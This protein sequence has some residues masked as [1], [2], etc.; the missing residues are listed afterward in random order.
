MGRLKLTRRV[1]PDG[2]TFA[3]FSK[4]AGSASAR[5]REMVERGCNDVVACSSPVRSKYPIAVTAESAT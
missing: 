1:N 4:G 5:P 2:K 3:V